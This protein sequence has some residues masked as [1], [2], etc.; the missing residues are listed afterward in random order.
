[1]H[2]LDNVFSLQYPLYNPTVSEGGRGWLFSLLLTS[3]PLY[4]AS[5]ALAAY[6]KR[7]NLLSNN[8]HYTGEVI[9]EERQLS[10]SLN[11]FQH[12][13]KDLKKWMKLNVCPLQTLGLMASTVQLIYYE[14]C[15]SR[16]YLGL[17]D[18]FLVVCW[19]WNFVEDPLASWYWLVPAEL[20]EAV[21]SSRSID[22]AEPRAGFDQEYGRGWVYRGRPDFQIL[23]WFPCM[24]RYS[25]KYYG[26]NSSSTPTTS[27]TYI[28]GDQY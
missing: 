15:K 12:A 8:R 5:L 24:A 1:M 4:H 3:P 11:E 2:F 18:K 7:I 27:S 6:H 16:L 22:T 17:A 21:T 28:I 9:E 25:F 13:L 20:L 19:P 26:R 10:T 23:L 14:V